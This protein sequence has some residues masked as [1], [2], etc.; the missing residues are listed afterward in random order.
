MVQLNLSCGKGKRM[1]EGVAKS[2][3]FGR[4][5]GKTSSIVPRKRI[6]KELD[7]T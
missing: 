4:N 7:L 3:E 2:L 6:G 5:T 1:G